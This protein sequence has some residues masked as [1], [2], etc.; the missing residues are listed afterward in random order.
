M[1]YPRMYTSSLKAADV[2]DSVLAM[3]AVLYT[4]AFEPRVTLY[5]PLPLFIYST[6][7]E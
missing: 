4:P 6:Y 3:K 2:H 5:L 1:L 7:C